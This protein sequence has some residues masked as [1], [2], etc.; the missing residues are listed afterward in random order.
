MLKG[1]LSESLLKKA[2]EK[3]SVVI[4][5]L[6]I[7]DEASDPH[8]TADDS[9]FGGGPGMV[10]LAEPIIR[11]LDKLKTGHTKT[12]FMTPAGEKLTQEKVKKLA[13]EEHLI[14]VCGHYEGADE[15]LSKYFDEEISIGD[16]VL[17]GGELPA[18]VLV[19]AICRYVPGVV[20]EAL[21]VEADSF[22]DGL[23]DFPH[24]TRPADLNGE[25][26]PEVLRG[27]N[28]EEIRKWR[29]KEALKRTFFRRPDL[30]AETEL[31]QEDREFIK[32]IVLGV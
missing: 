10:M 14:L 30:L 9:P 2:Q 11:H 16:Y 18:A 7:R 12:I 6:D 31:T 32:E 20:K 28:H 19:D 26:V 29:R 1:P 15:R 5:I 22:S 21:S 8:R 4:N 24:Y 23:L 17:T 25:T 27:G 3:G 13:K